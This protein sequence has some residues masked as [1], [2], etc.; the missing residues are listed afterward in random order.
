MHRP[1]P[2]YGLLL[3]TTACGTHGS[4]AFS[5]R[6]AAVAN[7]APV[8]CTDTIT[9]LGPAG[10]VTAGISDLRFYVSNLQLLD[11][12]GA[13]VEHT[14]DTNDF[15]Y[16]SDAGSVALIDL[17]G[18][19]EG[20]CDGGA[21]A[22][23]EGTA[24]TNDLLTGTTELHHV[25]GVRFD[26]G[27]PQDL[28]KA[29]IAENTVEGAPSP[30]NEM[31]WTWA[32]GYRHFVFNFAV[33]DAEGTRGDG[34]LHIGSMDCGPDDG[35]ALEDRAACGFVNT[36]TVDLPTFDLEADTVRIDVAAALRALDFVAPV[37]DMTTFEVIGEGPGV[38]CHSSPMQPD[39]P[40]I[41]GNF[42]VND[43]TGASDAASNTVFLAP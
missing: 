18:N 38:E 39:C 36:P 22:F 20:T 16:T 41:F 31:Y 21:V 15:Q 2:L 28:M 25:T 6:F 10:D 12:T 37:Y 17:T 27:V 35:L 14:L 43:L 8:T 4:E 9:G 29:V 3:L 33:T 19:T 7:D 40:T 30:L 42:G 1:H 11:E 5:L 32:S 34:Y 13:V 23:S 26:V 24:R